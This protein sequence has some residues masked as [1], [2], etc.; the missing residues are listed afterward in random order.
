MKR[1]DYTY[2][3]FKCLYEMGYRKAEIDM[4]YILFYKED[5]KLGIWTPR[6]PLTMT[7]I[8]YCHKYIDIGEYI[9]A[10]DWGNVAV[11]TPL[12]VRNNDTAY[13]ERRYFAKYEDGEIYVWP[14]GK[15]SWSAENETNNTTFKYAV[16]AD[17]R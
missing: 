6:L 12:Y 13:W 5:E 16:V 3:L 9:G 10:I 1:E 11:D 8:D 17:V 2:F 4:G 7:N 14:N 15:T